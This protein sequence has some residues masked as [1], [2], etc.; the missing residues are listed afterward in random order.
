MT[1]HTIEKNDNNQ[2]NIKHLHVFLL[3]LNTMFLS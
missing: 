3:T 2:H 1:K